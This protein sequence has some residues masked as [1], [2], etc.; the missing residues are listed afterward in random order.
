[1]AGS[2]FPERVLLGSLT[3]GLTAADLDRLSAAGA[4]SI[5]ASG[6][7]QL[8]FVGVNGPA[9]PIAVLSAARAGIPITPLNYRLA[10]D[11]LR[12]QLDR[13]G[14]PLV[15]ADA[16][17][18]TTV[19]SGRTTL[20]VQE[21]LRRLDDD[22]SDAPLP[23][24]E[25]D[26]VAVTLFTSGTTAA[27]KRVVLRH[28]HLLSYVLQTVDFASATEDDAGLI[29]VPPYHVAG[30]GTIL[31]NL[32][33]G[34]RVVYL[35]NFTAAAWLRTVREERIRNAMVVPTMLARI[36]EQL[37]ADPVELPSLRAIAYGGARIGLPVLKAALAL[38]PGVDFTNAYGLTET[39][40]TIAVLTPEDHR[41]AV[42]A[43][44]ERVRDRLGSAGRM[45][46]GA[47][48][49][50]RAPDGDVLPPGAVGELWVRGP[51]VSGEYLDRDRVLDDEGWFPTRDLAHFDEDGYL[52]LHGRAD[53]T[54]IRGGENI[55]PAEIEDV[56]LSHADV[57]DAGVTGIP[58][59]EWGQRI[60]AVVVPR[61]GAIVVPDELREWTRSR[62]RGSRTPDEIV[63]ATE[64][65][66]SP[67]GKLLR[68]RLARS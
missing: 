18:L 42:A 5:R 67:T 46:P 49:S 32:Y 22:R 31:T 44:D 33:A 21:F 23:S 38:L 20:E 13:L 57:Q 54:I 27:P 59:I 29:S 41:A 65:P 53:D 36:V 43:T 50:I 34:R 62:L 15:I 28:Q 2:A 61:P 10:A 11:A 6:T 60:L 47:E 40:S 48:A 68:S 14:D 7:A 16:D 56:L 35:P 9:F 26:A 12:E 45:V 52:F 64:L 24:V 19:E 58:D 25:D 8:A 4:R 3:D 30:I 17:H 51:Q 66:Y 63:L 1:M 55:S 37:A 39:S